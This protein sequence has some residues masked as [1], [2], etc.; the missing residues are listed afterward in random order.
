MPSNVIDG[1]ETIE[2]QRQVFLALKVCMIP[3]NKKQ[4][5]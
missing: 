4:Y 3:S 1:G 5:L 2:H